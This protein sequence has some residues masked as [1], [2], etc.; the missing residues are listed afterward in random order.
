MPNRMTH[1]ESPTV[2]G[3][4]GFSPPA[5][6]IPTFGAMVL[7][8]L[9]FAAGCGRP[10]TGPRDDKNQILDKGDPWQAAGKRLRS[11]TDLV[12]CKSALS[13]LN[14]ELTNGD[15][16]EKPKALSAQDEDALAAIVPL[17]STDRDEIRPAAFTP[18]DPVYLAECLYLRDAARSLDPA[19]SFP[20]AAG[21]SR[22]RLGVPPGLSQSVVNQSWG[23]HPGSG[24]ATG[25]RPPPR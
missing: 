14:N 21:R 23:S 1:S 12:A 19:R 5:L 25:L 20:R 17:H 24:S 4:K 8:L 9:I 10:P 18:H 2:L 22:F 6:S 11:D 3:K 15:K 16:A 13:S 7:G